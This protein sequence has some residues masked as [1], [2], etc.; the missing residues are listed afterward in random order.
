MMDVLTDAL[1]F[2]LIT[3]LGLVISGAAWFFRVY[4]REKR[5]RKARQDEALAGRGKDRPRP[6]V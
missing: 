2:Q 6:E 4:L 1:V 3:L 5:E